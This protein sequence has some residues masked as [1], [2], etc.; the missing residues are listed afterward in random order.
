MM[1]NKQNT[2]KINRNLMPH[3]LIESFSVAD[4]NS[5]QIELYF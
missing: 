4:V 5:T 1:K 2:I 3:F